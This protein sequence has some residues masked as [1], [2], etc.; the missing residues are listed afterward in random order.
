VPKSQKNNGHLFN[1]ILTSLW[2]SYNSTDCILPLPR[3]VNEL[4]NCILPLQL[5]K[6]F[7]CVTVTCHYDK[8]Q[9]VIMFHL[10]EHA[11]SSSCTV[12]RHRR[13]LQ[14]GHMQP[15]RL[16]ESLPMKLWMTRYFKNNIIAERYKDHEL[17]FGKLIDIMKNFKNLLERTP[18]SSLFYV[19]C[20]IIW[21]FDVKPWI[22]H[23]SKRANSLESYAYFFRLVCAV[24][25]FLSL[26]GDVAM[27]TGEQGQGIGYRKRSAHRLVEERADVKTERRM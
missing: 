5:Y 8:R 24:F 20:L 2:N 11:T 17:N 7:K 15:V 4:V 10:K 19:M 16:P 14:S 3:W 27:T 26:C 9:L 23:S 25:C 6:K 12:L 1:I 18:D 22:Q 13:R 21:T